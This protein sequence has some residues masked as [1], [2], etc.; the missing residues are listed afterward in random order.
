MD[1]RQN[2]HWVKGP[3]VMVDAAWIEASNFIDALKKNDLEKVKQLTEQT[4]NYPGK[5]DESVM[6][7]VVGMVNDGKVEVSFAENM[8]ITGQFAA[9]PQ[10]HL[11]TKSKSLAQTLQC[12]QV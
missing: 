6:D 11:K 12:R 7:T 2:A 4:K 8:F 5:F 10:L 1:K 3:S 9:N